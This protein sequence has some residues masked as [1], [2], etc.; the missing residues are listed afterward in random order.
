MRSELFLLILSAD[1][2]ILKDVQGEI[3]AL[4]TS[5]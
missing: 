4:L 2:E 3:P 5:T 1:L